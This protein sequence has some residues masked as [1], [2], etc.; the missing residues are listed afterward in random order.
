MFGALRGFLAL[1]VKNDV[2]NKE[3]ESNG[4]KDAKDSGERA[5]S[6]HYS[7]FQ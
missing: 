5:G 7:T 2:T 6:K 4:C 1:V 3:H